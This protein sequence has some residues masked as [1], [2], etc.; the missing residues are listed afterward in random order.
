MHCSE[1]PGVVQ[2]GEKM[3]SDSA[4]SDNEVD[5]EVGTEILGGLLRPP[6]ARSVRL[7][8]F[9]V[10]GWLGI[11]AAGCIVV[12]SSSIAMTRRLPLLMLLQRTRETCTRPGFFQPPVPAGTCSEIHRPMPD[13]ELATRSG[14]QGCPRS[15]L[16]LS[17]PIR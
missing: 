8:C 10:A 9:E 7:L 12:F 3:V 16:G 1:C 14:R 13:G 2:E 4:R 17:L 11:T 15:Y 6:V 5:E